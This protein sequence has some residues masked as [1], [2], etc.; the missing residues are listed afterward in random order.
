MPAKRR[1][2]VMLREHG[3]GCMMQTRLLQTAGSQ[4]SA[5]DMPIIFYD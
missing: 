3:T 2:G 5:S 4:K 1:G